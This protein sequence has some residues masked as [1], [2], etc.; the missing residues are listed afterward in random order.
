MLVYRRYVLIKSIG[1]TEGIM[2]Q[3]CPR[4]VHMRG[5]KGMRW[6]RRRRVISS[7]RTEKGANAR[8]ARDMCKGIMGA[9]EIGRDA[10]NRKWPHI[11]GMKG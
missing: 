1:R 3:R 7:R 5:G 8:I 10:E 4:R 6:N 11:E 9:W 2:R